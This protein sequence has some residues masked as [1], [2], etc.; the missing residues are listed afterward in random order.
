M[1][2][3]RPMRMIGPH[4]HELRIVDESAQWRVIYRLDVDAIIVVEVF[5]K[6]TA[7]TPKSIIEMSKARLRRYDS[8]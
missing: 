5:S 2:H 6:K 1:P 7:S 3:S 4:C 8:E